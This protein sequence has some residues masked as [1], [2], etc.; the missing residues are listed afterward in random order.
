MQVFAG[1]GQIEVIVFDQRRLI[2]TLIPKDVCQYFDWEI[3]QIHSDQ[4]VC[5]G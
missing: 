1:Q 5:S 4:F 2:L 3:K